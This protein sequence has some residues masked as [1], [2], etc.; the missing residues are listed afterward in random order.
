MSKNASK[1]SNPLTIEETIQ[2]KTHLSKNTINSISDVGLHQINE[3]LEQG[4]PGSFVADLLEASIKKSQE[5]EMNVIKA[6]IEAEINEKR[7]NE[8][9]VEQGNKFVYHKFVL[10]DDSKYSIESREFTSKR[11]CV[12]W[13]RLKRINIKV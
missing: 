6:K 3:M 1:N 2:A 5:V 7:F 12:R 10:I 8:E 11:Q 9:I 13:L 4:V